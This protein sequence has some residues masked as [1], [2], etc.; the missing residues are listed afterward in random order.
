MEN[1]ANLPV[2]RIVE[3]T[4]WIAVGSVAAMVAL[5]LAWS[6]WLAPRPTGSVL[7]AIKV[8]PLLAALPGLYLRRM[9]TYRWAS[10]LVWVYFMLAV[11]TATS[12]S[13]A[14]VPVAAC[15]VLLCL[16]LF[17]ACAIHVRIRL[18]SKTA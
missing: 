1:T 13:G 8:L 17:A 15:E 4:R 2:P 12:S 10:L 14:A 6:F 16:A 5:S 9:Y 7:F 11:V 3:A 18:R